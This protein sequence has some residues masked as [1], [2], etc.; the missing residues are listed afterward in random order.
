MTD[1]KA[2][3]LSGKSALV[4]GGSRGIGR[5]IAQALLQNG[6]SVH[7]CGRS[8]DSL[9][10]ARTALAPY[11]PLQTSLLDVADPAA[12]E[13]F[14]TQ[15]PALDIL[16]N[17]AGLGIFKPVADL[18]IADWQTTINTNLSGAFY[19]S[20]FAL[21]LLRKAGGGSII[22]ISSLAAKNPFATGAAYN[23]SKF[24][25]NGFAEAM[26]L[27]HR[28]DGIRITSIMPGSVATDFGRGNKE[29]EWKI[30]PEDIAQIVLDVLRM[31][32]RTLISAVEV[33]PS[34][35]PRK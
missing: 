27:D 24:G 14:F 10:E 23:A 25:L 20:R 18:D 33:R 34:Q 8:Q 5:A 15:L 13:A 4:T 9:D 7:I 35:P 32:A 12:V 28:N 16:I 3:L 6:A 22:N 31:P 29:G 17:N 21:P 19:C 11:G 30:Q 1:N 2:M 26:M